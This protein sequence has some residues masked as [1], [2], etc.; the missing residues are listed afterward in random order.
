M[1]RATVERDGRLANTVIEGAT[2]PAPSP[3]RSA[4]TATGGR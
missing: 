4:R 2:W 3:S 1:R